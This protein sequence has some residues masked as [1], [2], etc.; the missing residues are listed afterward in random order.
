MNEPVQLIADEAKEVK[1]A[2]NFID[3][4]GR[5][6]GRLIVISLA[7]KRSPKT[8]HWNVRCNC[9]K[10]FVT[11][12]GSLASG[13]TQS[14]GCLKV[15]TAGLQSLK[16]GCASGDVTPEYKTWAGIKRRCYN[17]KTKDYQRYG[18]R[19]IKVCDR[20]LESF[21][22][23]LEDMGQRPS[24][25]HSIDRHPDNNGNYEPGN[26]RWATIEEQARNRR[27]TK[28]ITL[29]GFTGTQGQIVERFGI[30]AATLRGRVN[31]GRMDMYSQS[32]E[33]LPS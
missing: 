24:D 33:V 5:R 17:V 16:H 28:L 29:W 1:R 25:Q 32:P 13:E 2:H 23:F 9:G 27:S 22:N 12:G 3:L 31:R 18:G 19:G 21:E 30:S 6:F 4:T 11:W 26:C 7:P 10:E 20:W 15:E 8:S 14:C